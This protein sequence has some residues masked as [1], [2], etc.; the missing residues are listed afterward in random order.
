MTIATV[1]NAREIAR[2][3]E[4]PVDLIDDLPNAEDGAENA[5][6]SQRNG[7]GNSF[8]RIQA[9]IQGWLRHWEPQRLPAFTAVRDEMPES[10]RGRSA[11]RAAA[12]QPDGAVRITAAL[13]DPPNREGAPL[14]WSRNWASVAV[15]PAARDAGRLYYRFRVS[16]RLVLDGQASLSLA[17]TSVNFGIVPD[18]AKA[19]PFETPGFAT[20]IFRPLVG[21][22]CREDQDASASQVFEGSIAVRQG[23]TPAMAFV[24]G[25]DLLFQQ[26]WVRVHEG[27]STWIGTSEPG[28][29]GT[30]E[31][32]YAPAAM[33]RVLGRLDE[34]HGDDGR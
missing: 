26:G 15:L 25:T 5:A 27:S 23:D 24:I 18:A 22:Q 20:P 16:S 34:P 3:D 28:A 14:S 17:S 1:T 12:T 4:L 11:L 33:L 2:L 10:D 31:F 9:G 21:V 13:Y 29:S 32:R 19:S 30:I 6:S 8:D 7:L